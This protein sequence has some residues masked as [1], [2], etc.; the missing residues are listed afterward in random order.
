MY[1][2]EVMFKGW[3]ERTLM[4]NTEFEVLFNGMSNDFEL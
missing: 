1:G 4:V 3:I 2:T